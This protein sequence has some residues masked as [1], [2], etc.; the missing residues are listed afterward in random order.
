MSVEL[1][2]F[3]QIFELEKVDPL[4]TKESYFHRW[5]V[6]HNGME[7]AM[8]RSMESGKWNAYVNF[9]ETEPAVRRFTFW[10]IESDDPEVAINTMSESILSVSRMLGFFLRG[11]NTN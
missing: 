3:G 1:N 10:G 4:R 5:M 8:V 6:V 2:L 9:E 7:I 11:V